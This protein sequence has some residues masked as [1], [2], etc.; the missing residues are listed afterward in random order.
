MESIVLDRHGV[1]N[2]DE[3]MLQTILAFVVHQD[4]KAVRELMSLLGQNSFNTKVFST[5]PLTAEE[6]KSVF[7][8]K[9]ESEQRNWS[10]ITAFGR[11]WTIRVPMQ[12]TYQ[13]FLYRRVPK[14]TALN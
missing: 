5:V 2:Q 4:P 3:S 10:K 13:K 7:L 11:S 12:G 14:E 9:S 8:R 1:K 6:V